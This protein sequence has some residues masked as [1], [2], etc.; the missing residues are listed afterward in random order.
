MKA[1]ATIIIGLSFFAIAVL[2]FIAIGAEGEHSDCIARTA[3]GA[4]CPDNAIA[5]I[6][7]HI[8]ALKSFST[9]VVA[10][11]LAI[12]LMM[13]LRLLAAST[14]VYAPRETTQL[15]FW[16]RSGEAGPRAYRSRLR[17]WISLSENS[18]NRF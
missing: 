8:G 10:A 14:S 18:P 2:G 9:A 4:I 3:F 7:F 11:G 17:S 5:F 1:L 6:D 15:F 12:L 16:H 13:V